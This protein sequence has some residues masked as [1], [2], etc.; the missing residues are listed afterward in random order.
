MVGD[1]RVRYCSGCKSNVYNFLAMTDAEI[2]A[3]VAKPEGRLCAR[4]YR[5]PDGTMLIQNGPAGLRAV[6]RRGTRVAGATLAAMMSVIPPTAGSTLFKETSALLQIQ[7]VPKGLQLEVEDATN[8]PIPGADVTIVNKATQK[9]IEVKTDAM[10]KV[11]VADL[12]PGLYEVTAGSPGFNPVIRADISVPTTDTVK[13]TLQVGFVGEIVE[14]HRNPIS[15]VFDKL[16]RI[17]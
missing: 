2:Q 5:R 10:G 3:L 14:V 6:M 17:F 12:P 8:A 9:K 15:K 16:R 13:L 7:T 4:F 11:D 1:D